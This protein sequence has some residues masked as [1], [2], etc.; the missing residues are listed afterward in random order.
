[1]DHAQLQQT[2][3]KTKAARPTWKLC[4]MPGAAKGTW[5]AAGM[6]VLLSDPHPAASGTSAPGMALLL[7]NKPESRPS[8]SW[9]RCFTGGQDLWL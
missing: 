6:S 8:A 5:F 1:M 3:Q 4:S 9:V 2:P 7:P